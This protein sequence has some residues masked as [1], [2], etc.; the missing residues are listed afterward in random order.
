MTTQFRMYE[1]DGL[2]GLT[3]RNISVPS[4]EE[5]LQA[6]RKEMAKYEREKSARFDNSNKSID[7]KLK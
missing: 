7:E 5:A 3:Y 1:V 2:F 6:Y 4:Q